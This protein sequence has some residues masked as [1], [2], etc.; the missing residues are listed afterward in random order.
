MNLEL[1]ELARERTRRKGPP[2]A[3]TTTTSRRA[4]TN[5]IIHGL[6]NLK[7]QITC[8]TILNATGC[9]LIAWMVIAHANQS[10]C[11]CGPNGLES[12]MNKAT[13]SLDKNK[14]E[15]NLGVGAGEKQKQKNSLN[16]EGL[17]GLGSFFEEL[18]DTANEFAGRCNSPMNSAICATACGAHS[19]DELQRQMWSGCFRGWFRGEDASESRNIFKALEEI[20]KSF[21]GEL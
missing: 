15:Q 9:I 6:A 20:S 16:L 8:A 18:I 11:G 13:K 19:G 1:A 17:E 12:I 3:T 7:Q 5:I 2:G 4:A 10:A 21:P 14:K